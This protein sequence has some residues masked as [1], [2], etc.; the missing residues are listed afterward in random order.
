M[1][2]TGS[3]DTEIL[4]YLELKMVTRLVTRSKTKGSIYV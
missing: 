3:V 4:G 1:V 2:T